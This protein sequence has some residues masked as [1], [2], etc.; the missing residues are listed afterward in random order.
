MKQ[1]CIECWSIHRHINACW[2]MQQVMQDCGSGDEALLKHLQWYAEAYWQQQHHH[3]QTTQSTN[4]QP[5]KQFP[6]ICD[7][8]SWWLN[9]P[10]SPIHH[11]GHGIRLDWISEWMGW[12][13]V[14][15]V[16]GE[17]W[18]CIQASWQ[19]RDKPN[20]PCHASECYRFRLIKLWQHTRTQH[21]ANDLTNSYTHLAKFCKCH[22]K[23]L[24]KSSPK[25]LSG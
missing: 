24:T 16:L 9:H 17:G 20:I 11:L 12:M 14:G 22:D 7:C 25:L 21:E 2:S 18:Q 15:C 13:M 8:G 5:T 10:D 6:K 4:Q 3:H 19:N 23:C 1:P